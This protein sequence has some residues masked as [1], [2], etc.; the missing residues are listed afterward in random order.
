MHNTCHDEHQTRIVT[1][2]FTQFWIRVESSGTI[3]TQYIG[4]RHWPGTLQLPQFAHAYWALTAALSGAGSTLKGCPQMTLSVFG[5]TDSP[6]PWLLCY[7]VIISWSIPWF[8][9][10]NDII[11]KQ[12][13]TKNQQSFFKSN[14]FPSVRPSPVRPCRAHWGLVMQ[15]EAFLDWFSCILVGIVSL[16]EL[17]D[18]S[19]FIIFYNDP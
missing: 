8:L 10:S 18:I 9:K 11:Y 6:C 14:S 17:L 13:W 16:L 1:N 7:P 3:Q 19:S 4:S 12:H 2:I 15:S 5:L